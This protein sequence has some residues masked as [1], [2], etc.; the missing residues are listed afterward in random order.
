MARSDAAEL[1]IVMGGQEVGAAL[2]CDVNQ[3]PACTYPHSELDRKDVSVPY[4]NTE[5]VKAAAKVAQ[6]EHLDE[7][8]MVIYG[9][10][11]EVHNYIV[12]YHRYS[13][14]YHE[15]YSI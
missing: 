6:E 4:C 12:T 3:C 14:Q 13:I 10:N 8:G 11:E 9:Q 2:T 7:D 15:Q 1:F 5:S